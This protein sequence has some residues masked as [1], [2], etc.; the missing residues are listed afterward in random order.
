MQLNHVE[1]AGKYVVRVREH[2]EE[3]QALADDLLI[4]VTSFFRDPPVFETLAKRIIPGL[5]E[6]KSAAGACLVCGLR[7]GRRG[8]LTG[9]AS[10]GRSGPE[11]VAAAHSGIR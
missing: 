4:T 7:N 5:F 3:A 1:D 8:L 6:N 11:A 10:R 2:P 9:D